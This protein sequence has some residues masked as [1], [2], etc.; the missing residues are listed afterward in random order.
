MALASSQVASV[1]FARALT[2]CPW[3]YASLSSGSS[4]LA[5]TCFNEI[6]LSGTVASTTG[7]TRRC[8]G[9]YAGIGMLGGGV[10]AVV[11]I[12]GGNV[13][14]PLMTL[15]SKALS[16]HQITATSLVAVVCTGAASATFYMSA[17]AVDPL[18]ATLITIAATTTAPVGARLAA[19][20][21]PKRLRLCLAVF[22]LGCAPLV[23]LKSW[24]FQKRLTSNDESSKPET[25]ITSCEMSPSAT[26]VIASTGAL[27][28]LTSGLLGIGGGVV[29]TPALALATD[30]P[31]V[32]VLGTSLT[33][34]IIPSIC[35][36]IVH[37]RA[38]TI[39]LPA[40]WPL[41]LGA[42]GGAAVGG[43]VAAQLPE[44]ELRWTFS[45]VMGAIGMVMLRK[46]L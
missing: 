13:M 31:Q 1:R 2:R 16:Q 17:G 21:A 10:G 25:S 26:L 36:A 27:A 20:L 28:G 23:P 15:S 14:V 45:V 42:A 12:G 11:G 41:A 30:L 7:V 18:A 24:L 35:G 6:R 29:L 4:R 38:G 5:R 3:R 44:K 33:A 43:R 22:V 46:A 39:V 9:A 8:Q 40:A 32:V 19:R 37:Y 34:M